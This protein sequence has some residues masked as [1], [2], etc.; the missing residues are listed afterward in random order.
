MTTPLPPQEPQKL[1]GEA[2][3]AALYRQLPRAEPGPGLDRDVLHAAAKALAEDADARA[4]TPARRPRWPIAWGSA[5]TVLLAAGLAWH[6]RDMPAAVPPAVPDTA[7]EVEAP[8]PVPA[9]PAPSLA[10]AP[11]PPPA[12]RQVP[13]AARLAPVLPGAPRQRKHQAAKPAS[14]AP[15]AAPQAAAPVV[16]PP[17]QPVAVEQASPAPMVAAPAPPAPPAPTAVAWS[18]ANELEAIRRLF[19]QG[20]VEQGRQRLVQ[21]KKMHPDWAIPDDLRAHLPQP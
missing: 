4:P 10:P 14:P 15:R 11:P 3:L 20:Q 17:T 7:V 1:P 6:M 19:A 5:A 12:I 16:E 13:L 9:E 8:P 21:F 2:E 18:P